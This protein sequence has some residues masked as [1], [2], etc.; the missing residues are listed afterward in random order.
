M[1]LGRRCMWCSRRPPQVKLTNEHILWHHL[2]KAGHVPGSPLTGPSTAGRTG[3][4]EMERPTP[5][6]E[7]KYRGLCT[8]CNGGWS[9]NEVDHPAKKALVEMIDPFTQ[10]RR[11]SAEEAVAV[12]RWA[13]KTL[14]VYGQSQGHR[15]PALL[16]RPFRQRGLPREGVVVLN[17]LARVPTGWMSFLDL[18]SSEDPEGHP[19]RAAI[20]AI[21][22]GQMLLLVGMAPDTGAAVRALG[23]PHIP[24]LNP[25][26]MDLL[27]PLEHRD[28]RPLS[29][30]TYTRA[31]LEAAFAHDAA[32][33]GP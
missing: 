14:L 24:D 15:Y 22:I 27:W 21:A 8:D 10:P 26:A 33:G 28:G 7:M 19:P 3:E 25:T 32:D 6:W 29:S 9:N 31:E 1:T 17:G 11:R 18:W 5:L 30:H 23:R 2:A 12:A 20:G 16:A 4:P 13:V